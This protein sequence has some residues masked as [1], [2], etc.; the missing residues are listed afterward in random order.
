MTSSPRC[1]IG[2]CGDGLEIGGYSLSFASCTWKHDC[3]RSCTLGSGKRSFES[4]C[5][6]K[7]NLGTRKT[8]GAG[9]TWGVCFDYDDD[10]EQEHERYARIGGRYVRDDESGLAVS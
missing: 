9:N 5:V 2:R 6:P 1:K 8:L 10:Y 3:P 7:C 4:T